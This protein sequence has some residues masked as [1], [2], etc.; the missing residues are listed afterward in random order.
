MKKDE[1]WSEFMDR[2][3]QNGVSPALQE[4]LD[5]GEAIKTEL[6]KGTF[7]FKKEIIA[8]YGKEMLRKMTG[9]ENIKECSNGS[10]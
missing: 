9:C 8:H 1:S 2:A 4:E 7:Y 10:D 5:T 3:K 6:A